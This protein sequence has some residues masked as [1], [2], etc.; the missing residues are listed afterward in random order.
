MLEFEQKPAPKGLPVIKMSTI[1][2]LVEQGAPSIDPLHCSSPLTAIMRTDE[3]F[4][5]IIEE[6]QESGCGSESTSCIMG[7]MASIGPFA[8]QV[9]KSGFIERLKK[10]P[11]EERKLAAETARKCLYGEGPIDLSEIH[12]EQYFLKKYIEYTGTKSGQDHNG[13]RFPSFNRGAVVGFRWIGQVLSCF[14]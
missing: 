12:D 2:E 10:I 1:A 3:N 9:T 13:F 4:N 6:L 7:L 5:K 14:D 8:H 11:K